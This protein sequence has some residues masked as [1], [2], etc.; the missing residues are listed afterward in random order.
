MHPHRGRVLSRRA[1]L[2]DLGVLGVGAVVLSGCSGSSGSSGASDA[3][4]TD[5][6]SA[7]DP[8]DPTG[9]G[10][11]ATTGSTPTSTEPS[12]GAR[13]ARTDLGFVSAYVLVRSGAAVVVDVGPSGSEDAIE[14]TLTELGSSWN[15]VSDVVLTHRHPD[16]VGSL[17]AVADRAS[18]ATYSTGAADLEAIG[19]DLGL[20]GLTDGDRVAGLRVIATPGHTPGHLSILDEVAGVLVA[21]DALNGTGAGAGSVSGPNP[22]FTA[23]LEAANASVRVLA[24]FD[25]EIVYFGHGEPLLSGGSAAVAALAEATG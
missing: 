22:D 8:P 12:G 5:P 11:T 1:L 9:T 6:T 23:D 18:A 10:D 14:A 3:G 13:W 25:Y 21:G 2:I 20:V 19:A 4:S 15:E 24:G 16:H 17:G 7:T